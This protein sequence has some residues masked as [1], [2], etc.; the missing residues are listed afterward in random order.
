MQNLLGFLISDSGHYLF[1]PITYLVYRV[2]LLFYL[3]IYFYT[4][5]PSLRLILLYSINLYL[6]IKAIET[7]LYRT[8]YVNL[9]KKKSL[10]RINKWTH[11]T[12]NCDIILISI[13][14]QLF[15]FTN[16]VIV[17]LNYISAFKVYFKKSFL[18]SIL[19]WISKCL[20]EFINSILS[21]FKTCCIQFWT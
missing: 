11:F 9:T 5:S 16:M 12:E 10:L 20:Y 14:Y 18:I 15:L 7:I 1:L 17:E 8:I 4:N 19:L 6:K 21:R 2:W 13:R 3:Y